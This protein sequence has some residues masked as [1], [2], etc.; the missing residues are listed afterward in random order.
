M[1][2]LVNA[3]TP[4]VHAAMEEPRADGWVEVLLPMESVE[5]GV[6]HLLSFG[7]EVEVL[8]PRGLRQ[9]LIEQAGAVVARYAGS[10]GSGG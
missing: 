8:E 5:H 6:R 1:A 4:F 10:S 9:A 7:S 3:R 2:W